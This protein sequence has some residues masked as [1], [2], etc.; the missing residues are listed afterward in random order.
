MWVDIESVI[1]TKNRA[2]YNSLPKFA[3]KLLARLIHQDE[4]N[5]IS[6]LHG[7][8]RGGE[9]ITAFLNHLEIKRTV[10][11]LDK[12]ETKGRYIFVSNHPLGGVDGI[13]LAEAINLKFGSVKVVVNDILMNFEPLKDIFTPINK[14]GRQ[15]QEYVLNLNQVYE[16][17]TPILY[18]PAGL[19]SRKI[20]GE[21]TDSVWKKNFIQK[22]IEYNR[23]IVPMFVDNV[24]SPLFYNVAVLRKKMGI[25]ANIEMA[26]L[27]NE[28]FKTKKRGTVK[29]YVGD[30]ITIDEIKQSGTPLGTWCKSIRER[31]YN[32][33][34]GAKK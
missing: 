19:C 9:F 22:A 24:N 23:D 16:S 25:K 3:F 2:L 30:N 29:V 20:K 11:N 34:G 10:E 31:C 12:I 8:L 21:I 28:I 18:F 17:D 14:H 6:M 13:V 4:I 27:P 32:L 33:K 15:S 5:E 7:H 1:K 26:L